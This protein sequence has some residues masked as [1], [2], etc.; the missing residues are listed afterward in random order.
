MNDKF[1][2]PNLIN[3]LY[4]EDRLYDEVLEEKNCKDAFTPEF[5]NKVR[6]FL[7]DIANSRNFDFYQKNTFERRNK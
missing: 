4:Y 1:F 6:N 7:Y 5:Q 2:S 3:I